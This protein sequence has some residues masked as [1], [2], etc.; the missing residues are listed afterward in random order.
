[1]S[2]RNDDH[3]MLKVRQEF[4]CELV[5]TE[6]ILVRQAEVSKLYFVK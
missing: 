1:M 6:F 3:L 5:E 4:D 2:K